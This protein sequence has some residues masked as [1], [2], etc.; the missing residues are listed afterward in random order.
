[1][2]R[3]RRPASCGRGGQL[4]PHA[5]AFRL[6][7]QEVE[8]GVGRAQRGIGPAEMVDHHAA[9]GRQQ[10]RK[11][12]RQ[13]GG[14]Q[15]QLHVPAQR[16]HVGQQG[17]PLGRLDLRQ[18][19]ADQVQPDAGHAGLGHGLQGLRGGARRHHRHAAQAAGGGAQRLEQVA[20]VRAQET[21]LHQHAMGRARAR[22]AA[23]GTRP[24]WRRS[25]ACG[26]A[27][28]QAPGLAGIRAHGCRRRR[29]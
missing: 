25:R 4:H 28:R 24:A 3:R 11:Q 14:G 29:R 5:S 13:P 17:L 21:G 12:A 6:P 19:Q 16:V 9:S 1:M 10:G 8:A 22:P 15:M 7:Q 26:G 2:R 23:P 27:C 18:G 20:V